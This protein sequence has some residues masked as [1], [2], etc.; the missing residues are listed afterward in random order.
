MKKILLI[1]VLFLLSILAY[2]LVYSLPYQKN[3]IGIY[4]DAKVYVADGG[5]IVKWIVEVKGKPVYF[6]RA[7]S[8]RV[9]K[10]RFVYF[11]F[12]RHSISDEIIQPYL[13]VDFNLKKGW[14]AGFYN[15]FILVSYENGEASVTINN[16]ELKINLIDIM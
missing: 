15:Y 1:Q 2:P 4:D 3:K 9:L 8:F 5:M 11:I 10:D 16:S 12:D 14:P 6:V 7:L 13:K